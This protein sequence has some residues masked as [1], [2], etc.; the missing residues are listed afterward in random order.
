MVV[1]DVEEVVVLL[2]AT[3]ELLELEVV[4]DVLDVLTLLAPQTAVLYVP[5]LIALFI[6]HWPE[7]GRNDTPWHAD[8]AAQL[9][10]QLSRVPEATADVPMSLYML[11]TKQTIWKVPLLVV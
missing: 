10:R 2:F 7:L 5:E 9:A 4:L 8:S 6:Q 11:S 1:D 3:E